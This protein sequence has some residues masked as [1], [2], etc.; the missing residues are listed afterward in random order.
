MGSWFSIRMCHRKEW[1]VE[2]KMTSMIKIDAFVLVIYF[3]VFWLSKLLHLTSLCQ[4][5]YVMNCILV[6]TSSLLRQFFKRAKCINNFLSCHMIIWKT[7]GPLIIFAYAADTNEWTI[8]IS[9]HQNTLVVFFTSDSR[10]ISSSLYQIILL[11]L[12]MSA[13]SL[14]TFFIHLLYSLL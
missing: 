3:C 5:L 7:K 8:I 12:L 10:P 6:S 4:T 13:F 14:S 9:H 1:E 2:H 11:M